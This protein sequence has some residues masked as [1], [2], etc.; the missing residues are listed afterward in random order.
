MRFLF[1]DKINEITET[2]ISGSRNFG[3]DAPMQYADAKGQAQIAPGVVSEAIGQLVSWLTISRGGFTKRPVFLFADK[4]KIILP[5]SPGSRVDLSAQ[6][7]DGDDATFVFSGEARVD[8]ELVHQVERVNG[9]YMPLDDLEDPKVTRDRFQR[10]SSAGLKLAGDEGRFDF[11]SLVDQIVEKKDDQIISSK[12]FS[13]DELFYQD[14]FPRFPVTPIVM[15]NEMIGLTTALLVRPEDPRAVVPISVDGIKIRN[16][17]KP[18]DTVHTT[19]KV[20]DTAF[21]DNRTII[22]TVAEVKKGNKTL[23]RGRYSYGI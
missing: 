9:F 19:V 11:T 17:V 18:G 16:F 2:S 13:P 10:L 12:C 3:C 7:D 20:V 6:I 21:E 5:V 1:V 22:K 15:I 14:H 23:L 4:I 8:G